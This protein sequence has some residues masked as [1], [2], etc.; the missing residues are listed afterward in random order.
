[1]FHA[2]RGPIL[3]VVCLGRLEVLVRVNGSHS[4][5]PAALGCRKDDEGNDLVSGATDEVTL[6]QM[7]HGILSAETG[8]TARQNLSAEHARDEI[9]STDTTMEMGAEAKH[10]ESA[11][12]SMTRRSYYLGGLEITDAEAH[13]GVIRAP[14]GIKKYYAPLVY[15]MNKPAKY[16]FIPPPE[17]PSKLR[18]DLQTSMEHRDAGARDAVPK[19]Q[20]SPEMLL[21]AESHKGL[22]DGQADAAAGTK[23]FFASDAT[24]LAESQQFRDAARSEADAK[25]ALFLN[26]A[27]K[28]VNGAKSKLH[29]QLDMIMQDFDRMRKEK[30]S[31]QGNLIRDKVLSWIQKVELHHAKGAATEAR[32]KTEKF[33]AL[34]G[35]Q[36]LRES[37]LELF[38][39]VMP[40]VSG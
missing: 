23:V 25:I 40:Q 34:H 10:T 36:R 27:Q 11:E 4:D 8:S 37:A 3:L 35:T 21:E 38:D 1:M 39:L 16:S 5:I 13:D 30:A 26:D 6:L 22:R 7:R 18:V 31:S 32:H 14:N 19:Q 29:E 9:S 12:R 15:H 17:P 2:L 28:L 33:H 20:V 24:A